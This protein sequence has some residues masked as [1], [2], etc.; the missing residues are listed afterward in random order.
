MLTYWVKF[1]LTAFH[2]PVELPFST[3]ESFP[4]SSTGSGQGRQHNLSV[5]DDARRGAT[6][7]IAVPSATVFASQF[8]GRCRFGDDASLEEE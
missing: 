8:P 1:T 7:S 6:G 2:F 4:P 3:L 5:A